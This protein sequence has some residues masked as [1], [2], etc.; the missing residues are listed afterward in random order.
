[1]TENTRDQ[2]QSKLLFLRERIGEL[3]RF[4]A[5]P[6]AVYDA[7]SRNRLSVERLLHIAIEA[8]LDAARLV[9]IEEQLKRHDDPDRS[10]FEA[11][12]DAAI[13]APDLAERLRQAH[14]FRN[15]LVHEYTKVNPA[16]VYEHV[17]NDLGDLEEFARVIA[18]FLTK[19]GE[20]V[21]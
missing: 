1:M 3:E 6:K 21:A 11:L 14:G 20:G 9:T 8:A 12:V 15:I 4:R 17:Q 10:V 13:I 2:I 18:R 5:M 19:D 16:L 7:D